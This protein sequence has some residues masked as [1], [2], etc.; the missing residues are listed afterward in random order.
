MVVT[1]R[2]PDRVPQWKVVPLNFSKRCGPRIR[3]TDK[4]TPALMILAE[5]IEM[6]RLRARFTTA[7]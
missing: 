1:A 6:T 4:H 5:A 2:N 3:G 7:I